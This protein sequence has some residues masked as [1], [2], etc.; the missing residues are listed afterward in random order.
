MTV[1]T[2]QYALMAGASY[3]DT[4]A[5][6]NRIPTPQGWLL[7]NHKTEDSGFEAVSFIP[8][9]TVLGT[10]TTPGTAN[11]IVISFAD[12][13]STDIIG[14]QIT[15]VALALG[16]PSSQQAQTPTIWICWWIWWT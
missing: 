15:N 2:I 1:S 6:L 13:D 3:F 12:T 8:E 14:D 7:D 9:G 11:E 5:E 4:R 16:N 10:S